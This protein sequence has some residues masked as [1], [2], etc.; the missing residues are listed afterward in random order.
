MTQVSFEEFDLND[1]FLYSLI[2]GRQDEESKEDLANVFRKSHAKTS[3]GLEI[4]F[5][6]IGLQ[7]LNIHRN[8]RIELNK[9]YYAMELAVHN[10]NVAETMVCLKKNINWET[11]GHIYE[12]VVPGLKA[13]YTPEKV[14]DWI[15]SFT[16]TSLGSWIVYIVLRIA[17]VASIY[18]DFVKDV[19]LFV[20]MVRLL[21]GPAALMR[22]PENFSGQVVF[23]LIASI[24]TPLIS[25]GI[26]H[27]IKS[28]F[29]ILGFQQQ[30][31]E[32]ANPMNKWKR[33][34]V[35]FSIVC[36]SFLNPVMLQNVL[37]N[38]K[39]NMT[40]L[41]K[42][43]L[44]SKNEMK[45]IK[46]MSVFCKE[47]KRRLIEFRKGEFAME[48]IFQLATQM[49]M[50]MLNDTLTAT[51]SGL[52]TIFKQDTQSD[53]AGAQAI[54][55]LSIIGSF[56]SAV[57]TSIKIK[58]LEKDDFLSTT[59]KIITGMR[60][61]MTTLLRVWCLVFFFTPYLGLL[62]ILAHWKGEQIP[63]RTSPSQ[64]FYFMVDRKVET[65]PFKVLNRVDNSTTPPSLP[66][67][68]LYTQID[69]ASAYKV[70]LCL[71]LVQMIVTHG[72]KY[73]TSKSYKQSCFFE[74]FVH[75]TECLNIPSIHSDW[76]SK[77]GNVD[78]HRQR[79]RQ[80]WREMV[81]MEMI[82][83]LANIIL[84]LPILVTGIYVRER[85]FLTALS[86]GSFDEEIEAFNLVT[87]L[88]WVLPLSVT[89]VA[90]LDLALFHLYNIN[91]HPWKLILV[92]DKSGRKEKNE[93]INL[94]ASQANHALDSKI[95]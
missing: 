16:A 87:L 31:A 33:K 45:V 77:G 83:W 13:K 34:I 39:R 30:M 79:W 24:F 41:I 57:S 40:L 74:K 59:G 53:V 52:E 49:S 5:S 17:R 15:D 60:S 76:D 22:Y 38:E 55:I 23:I 86:V 91:Y 54:L 29:L 68:S 56:L 48:I 28:P 78:Q 8:Q 35:Q 64:E 50:L 67:Y 95:I 69:L 36:C 7:S 14:K 81:A 6:M 37:E 65:I 18:F 9:K 46:E 93:D 73:F 27:A 71:L 58:K 88:M 25:S 75:L 84:V 82:T 1:F 11:C 94:E 19:L 12:D 43:A 80:V 20:T 61:L 44:T 92:D 62:N 32:K 3:Y 26:L 66:H 42:S 85:H 4:N 89:V 90:L 63:F 70:I 51:T 21:G 72:A 10:G 47:I 2:T